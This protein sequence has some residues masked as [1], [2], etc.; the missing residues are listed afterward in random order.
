MY[1]IYKQIY[2][3]Y[4]YYTYII[5]QTRGSV[6]NSMGF[7]MRF[8]QNWQSNFREQRGSSCIGY[9]Y[10]IVYTVIVVIV[11]PENWVTSS[12][13]DCLNKLYKI[14]APRCINYNIMN[15]K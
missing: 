1:D 12:G 2:V 9:T 6:S 13:S 15:R 5:C 3:L 10:S 8:F 11:M 14:L 4:K 7:L